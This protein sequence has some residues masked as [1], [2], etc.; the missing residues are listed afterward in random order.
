[1]RC[2]RF[3]GSPA[4]SPTFGMFFQYNALIFSFHS[5][6]SYVCI[7]YDVYKCRAL[8]DVLAQVRKQHC[9]RRLWM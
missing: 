7:V 2:P 8:R 4:G 6:D 1:M 5:N 3:K 9:I